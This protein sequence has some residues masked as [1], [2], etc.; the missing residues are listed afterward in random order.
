[1][2][3]LLKNVI[4]SNTCYVSYLR[5]ST[6]KQGYS[7]LGLEAQREIIQNHLYETTPITEFIE[8]ESGR[9]KDRPKL[10]EAL[11]LCR[12]TGSTLIVAK[13]DRLARN[14]YFLS[15]L[16]ESDV[17]IVFCDFPQANKMVLHILSAISQYEA[18]LTASR[19]KSALQAKKARGCKLGNPEHLLGKHDQAIQNSI[20]TCKTK[21]DNNPNNKRAVA[22]LRTLVKE[23]HTLKEMADILNR[24]GFV[25]S[26]GACFSKATVYKLIK[27]Y[28]LN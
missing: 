26:K 12:K 14:V 28:H 19:T 13:L 5:V 11:D 9:K 18:E 17:E 22:M 21:A 7:G 2:E 25:T 10:K 8:V 16:L 4:M 3:P 6:Q 1:M 20:M 24:E 27:R 23:E 15:S